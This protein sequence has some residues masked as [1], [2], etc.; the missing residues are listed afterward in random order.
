MEAAAAGR[1]SDK[2]RPYAPDT[3]SSRTRDS[4]EASRQNKKRK[5]LPPSTSAQ[6]SR[7]GDTQRGAS[8]GAGKRRDTVRS[9]YQDES[10]RDSSDEHTE[11]YTNGTSADRL[12]RVANRARARGG[13]AVDPDSVKGASNATW[14]S[15]RPGEATGDEN[16]HS[17]SS[18][19]SRPVKT[20]GNSGRDEQ[21]EQRYCFCNNVS[22]GD[23]IGCD[24]DDC[25]REWFHL[26]C[27]GLSKPPQGTWYCDACLERR[28]QQ[29]RNKAKRGARPGRAAASP[30]IVSAPPRRL[31]GARR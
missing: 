22:Y 16:E 28:S 11:A 13:P 18:G 15:R 4:H 21:D 17:R 27:V 26:G 3:S 5:V 9:G 20:S 2:T 19:R 23:M 29:A 6:R 12:A 10:D 1:R 24:D 25:E 8:S 14:N 31:A 7:A 30:D